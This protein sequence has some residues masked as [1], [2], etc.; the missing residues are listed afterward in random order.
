MAAEGMPNNGYDPLEGYD[1]IQEHPDPA[2]DPDLVVYVDCATQER[3]PSGFRPA[4]PVINIDHHQSNSRYGDI[5]WIEPRCA[6]TGEMIFYLLAR[7]GFRL[8]PAVAEI[9]L[10][11][12]T[13]DTGEFRY[14]NT[15]VN[16]HLVA[17]GL[18]AAGASPQRVWRMAYG[19]QRFEA[20]HITGAVMAAARLELGGALAWSE[21]R[22]S[23]YAESGGEQSAPK[24]SAT[25]S[26]PS[27]ASAPPSSSTKSRAAA[28]ALTSAP[29][30]P[31]TSA[32]SPNNSEEEA[33]PPPPASPS[34]KATTNPCATK[35]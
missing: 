3:G 5:Q 21:L 1:R 35:S 9:L 11:A 18:I 16:Q 19:S 14:A 34:N 2:L 27:A 29:T 6:A 10:V 15:G 28:S 20:L 4:A 13:T 33:T 30:A 24:T 26:A 23:V 31:S 12:L 25:A 8:T 32:P 22:Q 7:A 17:A